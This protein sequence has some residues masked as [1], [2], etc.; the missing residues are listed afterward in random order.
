MLESTASLFTASTVLPGIEEF[1]SYRVSGLFMC[2]NVKLSG[3]PITK[4]SLVPEVVLGNVIC[5]LLLVTIRFISLGFGV[6]DTISEAH[7][8]KSFLG[9]I[10]TEQ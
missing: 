10:S 5:F 4:K 6:A 9:P 1:N 8:M 3:K 7:H 2:T